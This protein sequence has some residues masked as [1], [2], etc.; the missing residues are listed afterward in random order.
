MAKVID[1][2]D[3]VKALKKGTKEVGE[4]ISKGISKGTQESIESAAKKSASAF[5]AATETANASK[6]AQQR[7]E[8]AARRSAS[9][10]QGAKTSKIMRQRASAIESAKLLDDL[11]TPEKMIKR[12]IREMNISNKKEKIASGIFTPNKEAREAGKQYRELRQ[13]RTGDRKIGLINE[14]T[15]MFSNMSDSDM[16]KYMSDAIISNK[17]KD[18]ASRTVKSNVVKQFNKN[19]IAYRAASAGVGGALIFSMANNKGQQSNQQLY[20]Q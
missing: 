7:V 1:F 12:Q 10:I 13:L 14:K 16:R 11:N 9:K 4:S 8:E 3:A 18:S 20:G 5:K 15:S 6:V 17:I 2:D 19:N